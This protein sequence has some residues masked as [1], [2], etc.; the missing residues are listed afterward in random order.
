MYDPPTVIPFSQEVAART[1]PA[2]RIVLESLDWNPAVPYY[3]HR[4]VT[5]LP[6]SRF[7]RL[8]AALD[9]DDYDTVVTRYYSAD[10]AALLGKW[11]W[12]AHSGPNVFRVAGSFDGLGD[13]AVVAAADAAAVTV[14]AGRALLPTPVTLPCG[15][16]GVEVAVGTGSTWLRFDGDRERRIAVGDP[17]GGGLPAD[18]VFVARPDAAVAG[19][20]RVTCLG[21]GSVRLLEAV[22]APEPGR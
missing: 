1:S 17:N 12:V 6:A 11:A 21:E 2:D 20:L 3:A 10:T 5:M 7:E 13:R 18:R 15:A 14:P 16:P 9:P 8:L 4:E 19:K 22:D